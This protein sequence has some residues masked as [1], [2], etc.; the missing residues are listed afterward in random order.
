MK[1]YWQTLSVIG[2]IAFFIRIALAPSTSTFVVLFSMLA[3]FCFGSITYL[4]CF[5]R[6]FIV[7]KE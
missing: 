6:S 2:S 3:G 1:R 7:W 5:S 4:L